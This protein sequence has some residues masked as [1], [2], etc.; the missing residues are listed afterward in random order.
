MEIKSLVQVF[1]LPLSDESH[2]FLFASCFKCIHLLSI[3]GFLLICFFFHRDVLVILLLRHF[4]HLSQSLIETCHN[5]V[6]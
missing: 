4:D 3:D 6:D 5:S 2:K 1:A